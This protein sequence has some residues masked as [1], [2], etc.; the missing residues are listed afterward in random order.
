MNKFHSR[1]REEKKLKKKGGG[2]PRVLHF[3][4]S[5]IQRTIFKKYKRD[6]QECYIIKEKVV[7]RERI[8]AALT[9][10]VLY[11]G[12]SWFAKLFRYPSNVSESRYQLVLE[13]AQKSTVFTSDIAT[14]C[15]IH[16]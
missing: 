4:S 1:R 10:C 5:K 9:H 7:D 3:T 2:K 14:R 12:Q 16:G 11:E 6:K 15:F 13:A 8:A